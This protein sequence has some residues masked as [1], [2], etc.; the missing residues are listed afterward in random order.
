MI[1]LPHA[2]PSLRTQA[3]LPPAATY[4]RKCA[5]YHLQSYTSSYKGTSDQWTRIPCTIDIRGQDWR[6]TR[7]KPLARQ[8]HSS[9]LGRIGRASR[10]GDHHANRSRYEARLQELPFAQFRQ[11]A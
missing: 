5:R 8:T 11:D 4:I 3:L 9:A 10:V 6:E 2:H 1:F 7:N